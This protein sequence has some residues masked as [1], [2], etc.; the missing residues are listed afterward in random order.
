MSN[1]KLEA[2]FLFMLT[3]ANHAYSNI[4]PKSRDDEYYKILYK[5]YK[6]AIKIKP[7]KGINQK[8]VK[9]L[10]YKFADLDTELYEREDKKYAPEINMIVLIYFLVAEYNHIDLITKFP[11]SK[12]KKVYDELEKDYR[13]LCFEVWYLID[14][15]VQLKEL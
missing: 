2:M 15:F 12:I 13:Q 9:K 8:L 6:M 14:R 3:Y 10:Y 7:R 11:Y 1:E 5:A 4:E